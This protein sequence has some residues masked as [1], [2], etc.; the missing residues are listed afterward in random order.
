MPEELLEEKAEETKVGDEPAPEEK[1]AEEPLLEE[2]E[3]GG[4]EGSAVYARKEHRRRVQLEKDLQA[5]REARIAAE[6]RGKAMEEVA[7]KEPEEKKAETRRLTPTEVRG[8]VEAGNASQAEADEYNTKTAE[9][10]ALETLR[11]EREAESQQDR[12]KRVVDKIHADMTSYVTHVPELRDKESKEFRAV[13]K[14]FRRLVDEEGYEDSIRTELQASRLILGPLSKFQRQK[15]IDTA[16]RD[17]QKYDLH[18]ET[19]AGGDSGDNGA[20]SGKPIVGIPKHLVE[21]WDK[22]NTKP[23]DRKKEAIIW[24][25]T[26]ARRALR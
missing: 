6:A 17:A 7:K 13:A 20:G 12:Q 1:P 3:P 23:E 18:S 10:N 24:R 2:G 16:T 22:T 15:E 5:E 11:K 25:Q 21:Y 8:A 14:E 26:H 4:E 19:G 9:L